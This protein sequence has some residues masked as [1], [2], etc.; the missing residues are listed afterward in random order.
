MRVTE[1]DVVN[2]RVVRDKLRRHGLLFDIPDCAC[3]VD[4]RGAY[5]GRSC[6]VP[7]ETGD[8]SAVLRIGLHASKMMNTYIARD[9]V[10]DKAHSFRVLAG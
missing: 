7:V 9:L 1:T 5:N 3:S 10:L 8:G 6:V 4:R 2:S